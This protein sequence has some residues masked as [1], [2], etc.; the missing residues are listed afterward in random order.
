MSDHMPLP[1]APEGETHP[2]HEASRDMGPRHA[3]PKISGRAAMLGV[4][5]LL[6]V[7]A[8]LALAGILPRE[9]AKHVLA[10]QTITNAEPVVQV[11]RP[12]MGAPSEDLVLP[13]NVYAWEDS[14]I[15]ARTSGYLTKWYFDIGSHVRKGQLLATIASPEVD[16]ELFQAK[17]DL[18]T[19]EANAANAAVQAKR[20]VALLKQNAV[21]AQDRDTFVTQQESTRT[22]VNSAKANVDRLEQMVGFEKIYAPFSG[23]ITARDVDTGTL[24]QNGTAQELFHIA[25]EHVLRVYVNVPQVDSLACVPGVLAHLTFSEFPN[26]TFTGRI[27]RTSKSIDPTTR[28]LLVEVDVDNRKGELYPGMFTQVHFNLQ[29]KHPTLILPASS[30]IFQQHGLQVA[31]VRNGKIQLIPITI[32]QNDGRV[33][34]VLSG[35]NA[36]DEVLQ[37]PPDSLID[38]EAVQTVTHASEARS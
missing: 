29:V 27:V 2:G 13:G 19:A 3:P 20:Y 22:Q 7:A 21:S 33:V 8:I 34:Q 24:I 4:V 35:L 31:I 36:Q 25:D 6:V 1:N 15:Y 32:G 23:T 38:G 37:N 14:P 28:T 5:V 17:A 9:H 26:R 18:A 16:Q 10:E 11:A 12:Q 30:L